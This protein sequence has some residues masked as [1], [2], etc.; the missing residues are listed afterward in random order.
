MA[1]ASVKGKEVASFGLGRLGLGLGLGV[2][3]VVLVR[4]GEASP[5]W[6]SGSQKEALGAEVQT[7]QNAPMCA[8]YRALRALIAFTALIR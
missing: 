7:K 8:A 4:N 3:Q 5:P 2:F 1:R 6:L